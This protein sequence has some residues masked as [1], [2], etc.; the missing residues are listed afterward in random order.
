MCKNYLI[1]HNM[2]APEGLKERRKAVLEHKCEMK[3]NVEAFTDVNAQQIVCSFCKMN[4]NLM[5][6]ENTN[7]SMVFS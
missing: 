1:L 3:G 5:T 6:S 4:S 2:E 7:L